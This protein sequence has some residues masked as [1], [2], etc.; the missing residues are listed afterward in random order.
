MAFVDDY[1]PINFVDLPS[2]TTPIDAN[3]LNKMDKQI[4]KLTTFTS[5]IDPEEVED[6]LSKLK[7]ETSSLKEDLVIND[8][9]SNSYS[10]I[11]LINKLSFINGA[12]IHYRNG[13]IISSSAYSY[14]KNFPT[15]GG[16]VYECD[17]DTAHICF[18]DI[19][20]N[21]ISGTVV[22]QTTGGVIYGSEFVS[23]NN[24]YSMCISMTTNTISG[25]NL[26]I[27]TTHKIVIVDINGSGN[28]T[29]VVEAVANEPENSVILVKPGVYDGTVQAF[30]KRIILIG[31]DRNTCVIRSTNGGYNYPAINGSCG[32]FENLTVL[33]EYVN[34]VSSEISVTA[35][36]AAYAFHCENEYGVGKTL[37]FHHCTLKS[38][39]FSALGIGVRKDFTL[40]LDDC[41]LINNQTEN[42]GPNYSAYGSDG[43]GLGAMFLH[44]SVG[45]QGNSY[46]KIKDTV[47]K[48]TLGYAMCLYNARGGNNKVYCEFIN[49]TLYD[50][51]SGLTNN[52][53][54]RGGTFENVFVIKNISHGNTN[55]ELNSQ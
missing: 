34:G 48:S 1:N 43:K 6:K 24:A 32:Y 9:I 13:E 49:N 47:F 35:D 55:D 3:N 2:E 26:C 50:E 25:V 51:K 42:R 29:S 40:I 7:E 10:N 37:E 21:Y 16:V 44:D 41:E 39:F 17:S 5:T 52:L 18:Y 30:E 53:F 27:K 8:I 54:K 23:P 45:E 4:K 33:S 20:G 12:Y 46:L 36:T 38:D 28:Y 22:N 19:N 31:T 14:S 11:N 15:K